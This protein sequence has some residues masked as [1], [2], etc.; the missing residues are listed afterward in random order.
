M[1]LALKVALQALRKKSDCVQRTSFCVGQ[2]MPLLE[3][4]K[5]EYSFH[6]GELEVIVSTD[7]KDDEIGVANR[8]L[9]DSVL[10]WQFSSSSTTIRPL[11]VCIS[12]RK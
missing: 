8:L 11:F 10:S 1:R 5:S 9:L 2:V 4:V 6:N 7:L 12:K 3:M